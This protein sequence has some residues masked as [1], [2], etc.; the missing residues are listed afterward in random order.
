MPDI[1]F[2]HAD[3]IKFIP[4]VS[5][6]WPPAPFPIRR[7]FSLMRILECKSIICDLRIWPGSC[8]KASCGIAYQSCKDYIENLS[9]Y[10]YN[11]INKLCYKLYFFKTEVSENN[12]CSQKD[13]DFLGYCVIHK[14]NFFDIKNNLKIYR[15]Y[16]TKSLI[17]PPL[18][19]GEDQSNI[20]ITAYLYGLSEENISIDNHNFKIIGSYF[21][22]QNSITNC[23]VHS[24]IKMSIRWRFQDITAESINKVLNIDHIKRKGNEGL[25][26][27]EICDVIRNLSGQEAY[28]V[29]AYDYSSPFMFLK[30]IYH[31]L[32][33]RLPVLFIFNLSDK[34]YPSLLE[35]HA[36]SIIG[37][38]F[39]P[40]N[41]WSYGLKKYFS[42]D[43]QKLEY[44]S[45][46]IWCDNFIIQDDNIGPYYL[47]PV[48]FLITSQPPRKYY[49]SMRNLFRIK[50]FRGKRKGQ[51]S[52]IIVYPKNMEFF[53]N[54]MDVEPWTTIRI[55]H[56]VKHLMQKGFI[57][58]NHLLEKY[59]IDFYKQGDLVLRT[60]A[61]SKKEYIDSL[62][63]QGE[64][65]E[66]VD[67]LDQ[68]LPELF[69]LVEVSIPELYWI[70]K[71]K[72]GDIIIDPSEFDYNRESGIRFIRI[73]NILGFLKQNKIDNREVKIDINSPHFPLIEPK[74]PYHI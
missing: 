14:D 26:P 53:K 47:L 42:A 17:K 62:E 51:T 57:K 32:E 73:L 70:N 15:S 22:Q 18:I 1:K 21:S 9:N 66:Y 71:R 65:C 50:R 41:W 55:K 49:I 61:L 34:N 54:V 24:A 30:K 46:F 72:I 5:E 60:L 43:Y 7:I 29:R 4:C 11:F 31:A 3:N 56:Y 10:N 13:S 35:G 63:G 6:N 20:K 68:F 48:R 64:I 52:A 8:S 28:L 25:K 23:C 38:T 39:N 74:G 36:V 44:L 33:S 40:H 45:S 12:L 58:D 19:F 67:I 2:F 69:W 27:L 59:F 16:L 37:H